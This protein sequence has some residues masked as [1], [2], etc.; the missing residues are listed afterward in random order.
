MRQVALALQHLHDNGVVH[1]D[2]KPLNIVRCPG[3]SHE[4]Y[5]LIDLDA[6]ARIG[7]ERV[8][9]KHSSAYVPPEGMVA[10]AGLRDFPVAHPSWDIHSYGVILFELLTSTPLFPR[11][12]MDDNIEHIEARRQLCL[13]HGPTPGMLDMMRKAKLGSV[14]ARQMEAA[15]HLVE[16]CLQDAAK[17]PTIAQ[18]LGHNLFEPNNALPPRKPLSDGRWFQTWHMFISHMQAQANGEAARLAQM[19]EHLG[20]LPWLDMKATDLTAGGMMYGVRNSKAFV[21]L[22]TSDVLTRP[23]C[24]LE[25]HTAINAGRILALP[26]MVVC[27]LSLFH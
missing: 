14:D 27:S 26:G 11:N 7:V 5:M 4:K 6:A 18:I 1:A 9:R 23:F 17:R 10:I 3:S 22:L 2:L 15:C 25:I 8:G 12:A 13:W 21:L 20:G 24:I 19:I 16:W